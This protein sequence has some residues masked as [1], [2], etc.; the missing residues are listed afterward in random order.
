[1]KYH[2]LLLAMLT[3]LLVGTVTACVPPAAA[4]MFTPEPSTATLGPSTATLADFPVTLSDDLGREVTVAALPQRV[5][6]LAPSNTEILFALGAG[7]QVV[8][9][10]EFCNY[11]PEAQNREKIGG[12]SAKTISLEKIVSLEPDLVFSAGQPQ[13]PVI[14]ALEQA[15][16]PVFALDPEG[17]EGVYENIETAG[18][19]TGHEAEAAE[20][21]AEMKDRVAAVTE[22][23][24]AIPEAERPTVFYEVWHEPLM[25]A[26]P[27]TFI[28]ELIELAGGKNIFADVNEE[29]P[30][31]SAETIIQ[32]DPDVILG[33]DS[34][35]EELTADKIEARP[36]W[37]DIHAVQEGRIYLVN[38]DIVS[39]PGPRLADTLE[40]IARALHPDLF[41]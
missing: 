38:G 26:G 19:L 28:G 13:Q 37:G 4:P 36:G 30:Q 1:M 6:S 3:T 25:T 27:T 35:G 24:Q 7:D 16:I 40:D 5:I 23:T 21:V 14:E 34:H 17:L 8:G 2:G 39:R 18:Q 29:Y 22:K 11:P 33:P 12:F 15:G 31:V 41:R 9:V 32:R 20:V 10:T